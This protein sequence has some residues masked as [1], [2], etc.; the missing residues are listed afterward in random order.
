MAITLIEAAKVAQ[1]RG[2]TY[3]SGVMELYAQTSDV[4]RVLPFE[5]I[6]GN[7]IHYNREEAMPGV[8][9]RG[10]NEG[11]T[12]STGILNPVTETLAIAGGE[13]D[14]D[15]FI[16]QTQGED[17]RSIQEAMKIRALSA[18]WTLSFIKGDNG[19]DPRE[20]SGL[21]ARITGD[22]LISAGTTAG[23][24]PLSLNKLD[25]LIDQVDDPTHLIMNR[26]MRRRLSQAAR[27]PNVGGYI[28]YEKDE[29]GSRVMMYGDLPILIVDKD[30]EYNEILPFAEVASSGA[31][32]ASSIYCVS[33]ADDGVVGIE[34][35]GIDVRDLG[36]LA[37]KPVYRT[38]VEWYAGMMVAKGRAAAR[39]RH[40]GDLAVTA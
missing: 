19:G 21:Q 26:P 5:T 34:N 7:A 27:D 6:Q 3:R 15:R 9:F 18:R 28:T 22:Q 12:E 16:V 10:V 29:F 32:T 40:I 33:M 37:S 4:L 39:L 14:V 8:G 17:Q 35:G 13:L 36:E 38:R 20:F 2:D 30:N 31:S 24:A 23:G 1:G 25:E 11:Y